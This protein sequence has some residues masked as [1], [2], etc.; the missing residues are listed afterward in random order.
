MR[1]PLRALR[2]GG[3]AGQ[4]RRLR[5]ALQTGEELEGSFWRSATGW[6]PDGHRSGVTT[7]TRPNAAQKERSAKRRAPRAAVRRRFRRSAAASCGFGTFVFARTDR[8]ALAVRTRSSRLRA[9]AAHR[10]QR[11]RAT[12]ARSPAAPSGTA[13]RARPRCPGTRR[14]RPRPRP[15]PHLFSTFLILWRTPLEGAEMP[16]LAPPPSA[17]RFSMVATTWLGCGGRCGGGG[18]CGGGGC[19]GWRW[20]S[21]ESI[22]AGL[23]LSGERRASRPGRRALLLPRLPGSA[24]P[25]PAPPSPSCHAARGGLPPPASAAHALRSGGSSATLLPPPLPTPPPRNR[26]LPAAAPARPLCSR[27]PPPRAPRRSCAD[28]RPRAAVPA[29]GSAAS[30]WPQG[31]A[32]ALGSRLPRRPRGAPGRRP[33]AGRG[34]RGWGPAR[35]GSG[36]APLPPLLLVN[37][38]LPTARRHGVVFICGC[39]AE[40]VGIITCFLLKTQRGMSR[41]QSISKV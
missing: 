19:R 16:L 14:P 33:E 15:S 21:G 17:G 5:A 40:F 23:R 12:S 37:F 28:P 34:A 30:A 11:L 9:N 4:Q 10:R 32:A 20:R 7:R 13:P 8:P 25:S 41:L 39:D 2:R 36:V 29:P 31:G 24:G 38:L 3:H 18:G 27:P 1:A 22:A 26:S 35:P 6:A